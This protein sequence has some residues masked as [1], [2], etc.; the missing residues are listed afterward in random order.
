MNLE[1]EEKKNK[2]KVYICKLAY[3]LLKEG[4]WIKSL[5]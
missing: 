5:R 3:F 2:V 4:Q 1:I